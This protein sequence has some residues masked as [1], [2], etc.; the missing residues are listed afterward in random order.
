MVNRQVWLYANGELLPTRCEGLKNF[1][2]IKR[3]FNWVAPLASSVLIYVCQHRSCLAFSFLDDGTSLWRCVL[4]QLL[5]VQD[6][7]LATPYCKRSV[8]WGAEK[9][10]NG[11][12]VRCRKKATLR[13]S[14]ALLYAAAGWIMP[15]RIKVFAHDA[16]VLVVWACRR[17]EGNKV[18]MAWAYAWCECKKRW[19]Y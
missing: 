16:E 5:H 18:V 11:F 2:R 13:W 10:N 8:V 7:T 19:H 6:G 14:L 9:L 4:A 15:T 3:S 17:L 1:L 12:V